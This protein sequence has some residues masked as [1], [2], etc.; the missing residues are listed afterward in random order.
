M[1]TPSP[2][3]TCGLGGVRELAV[4]LWAALTGASVCCQVQRTA[5]LCCLAGSAR[6]AL[7]AEAPPSWHQAGGRC[8]LSC[9]LSPAREAETGA[10]V[11]LGVWG[12]GRSSDL[13]GKQSP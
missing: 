4:P 12:P 8:F 10:E 2:M 5:A 1:A 9:S 11:V 6:S 3:L 13:S 7:C